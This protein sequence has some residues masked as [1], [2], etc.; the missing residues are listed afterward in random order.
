MT[1][2]YTYTYKYYL[3]YVCFCFAIST[4]FQAFFVSYLVEPTYEKK[5]ETLDEL[6]DSDLVFG[7]NKVLL[8]VKDT[9]SSHQLVKFFDQK[10]QKEEC[11]GT[12]SSVERMITE[13]DMA[14]PSA[15]SYAAYRA[16][17]LGIVDVGKI[18]CPL[19][20]AAILGSLIIIFK[21]GN[22]LLDRINI[23]M[24]RYLEAGFLE[25]L[26][27]EL[28]HRASLRGQERFREADGDIFFAFSLSH[29]VPAFVVLL[30]GTVLS[31]AVFIGELI[32]NCLCRR[33]EKKNSRI[34]RV[35]SLL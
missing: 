5:M 32:V 33:R 28:Q 9:F 17:E 10:S 35:K 13:R 31:S 18:I 14:T 34:R 27:A 11:T 16:R 7:Y 1:H 29:L 12:Y 22:P 20:E 6:V 19:N 30:V 15:T 21:K 2:N 24:R 3:L 4:V 25:R 26:W 8:Y 23:L